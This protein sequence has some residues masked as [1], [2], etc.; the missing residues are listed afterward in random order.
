[1]IAF[2]IGLV[3]GVIYFG[4]LYLSIQMI[5]TAKHPSLIMVLSFVIRIGILGGVFYY[6]SKNG[7]KDMII[8][9][10]GVILV[11]V[12]MTSRLK[13]QIPNK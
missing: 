13:S 12:I 2:I 9:L 7:V 1:M 3:L 10:I 8:V 5:N 4:G 11:R 6:I